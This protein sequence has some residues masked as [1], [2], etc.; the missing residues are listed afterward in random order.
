MKH[1]AFV[2]SFVINT[3]LTLTFVLNLLKSERP[4]MR[5]TIPVSLNIEHIDGAHIVPEHPRKLAQRAVSQVFGIAAAESFDVGDF[6]CELVAVDESSALV[7]QLHDWA[8]QLTGVLKAPPAAR[9]EIVVSI[10]AGLC[11]VADD[12][13]R[14][15]A[16]P[17]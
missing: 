12:Y 9:R 13:E 11:Q 1:P 5:V 8:D 10:V 15:A 7:D 3:S 4:I 17:A 6:A 2:S 16:A 14:T